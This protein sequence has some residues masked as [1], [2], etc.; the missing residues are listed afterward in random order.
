MSLSPQVLIHVKKDASD[1]RFQY[2][3]QVNDITRTYRNQSRS[4]SSTDSEGCLDVCASCI[5]AICGM[6]PS[7]HGNTSAD[8]T[9]NHT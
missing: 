4:S 2:I 9:N 5:G 1:T 7:C 6:I 3:F 8:F